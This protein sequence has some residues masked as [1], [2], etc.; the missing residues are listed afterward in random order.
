M[1]DTDKALDYYSAAVEERQ[2]RR[3]DM[4][5]EEVMQ[6]AVGLARDLIELGS[7]RT[8]CHRI[9]FKGGTYPDAETAQGGMNEAALARF[10][11]ER[12]RIRLDPPTPPPL[13]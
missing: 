7:A 4:T 2:A 11:A 10:F 9:E 12:L 8:K 6:L 3:R 1:T 5:D 13:R